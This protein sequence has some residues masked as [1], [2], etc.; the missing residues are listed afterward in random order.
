MFSLLK[1][2][3]KKLFTSRTTMRFVLTWSIF[4]SSKNR[5]KLI[6]LSTFI[7]LK[8][9]RGKYLRNMKILKWR[10]IKLIK[11]YKGICTFVFV[12]QYTQLKLFKHA[13]WQG[14]NIPTIRNGI[15]IHQQSSMD[16][17]VLHLPAFSQHHTFDI[18]QISDRHITEYPISSFVSA[19]FRQRSLVYA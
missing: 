4:V 3:N 5:R 6:C 10:E 18:V 2:K 8:S 13:S 1:T 15:V 12:R 9:C 17:P 14:T 19:L 11:R 7:F 16:K